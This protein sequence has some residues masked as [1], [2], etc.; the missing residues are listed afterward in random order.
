MQYTEHREIQSQFSCSKESQSYKKITFFIKCKE[1]MNTGNDVEHQGHNA[2]MWGELQGN[3]L[4][5]A[6]QQQNYCSL[7]TRLS[8]M[9]RITSK[10]VSEEWDTI[11][12]MPYIQLR[13]IVWWHF[14]KLYFKKFS[15]FCFGREFL[16]KFR[17]GMFLYCKIGA[18]NISDFVTLQISHTCMDVRLVT[19]YL[20]IGI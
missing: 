13:H 14:I 17:C 1:N 4:K 12:T 20:T 3:G 15:V 18:Q 9:L 19:F 16:N 10:N 11:C 8:K 2:D 7:I 5:E 6:T